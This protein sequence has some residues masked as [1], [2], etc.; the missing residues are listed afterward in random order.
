VL[1]VD[2]GVV[3]PSAGKQVHVRGQHSKDY[4]LVTTGPYAIVR[5]PSY[6]GVFLVG[7]STIFYHGS[8][9]SW[10]VESG[11]SNTMMGRVIGYAVVGI[12]IIFTFLVKTRWER[13]DRVL[14]EVFGK[15]WDEWAKRVPYALVPGVI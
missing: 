8:R 13:E 12:A 7:F 6:T 5:H 15:Q 2:A 14:K 4:K 9:G 1:N 11:I 3:L 10:F